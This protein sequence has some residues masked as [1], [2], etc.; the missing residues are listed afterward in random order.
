MAL[1][2]LAGAASAFAAIDTTLLEQP[3][4]RAS[5]RTFEIDKYA[6]QWRQAL[7]REQGIYA[8]VRFTAPLGLQ[9]TWDLAQDYRGMGQQTPG[10][11]A[12]RFMD[13]SPT[14]QLIEL[15]VR[16]LWRKLTLR[17]AVEREAPQR[18]R[19]ALL[20][21]PLGA[22]YGISTFT[23]TDTGT[24]VDLAIYLKPARRVPARLLLAVE[25]LAILGGTRAFLKACEQ[26]HN[27]EPI[28]RPRADVPFVEGLRS[29][30]FRSTSARRTR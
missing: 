4:P 18:L 28:K 6:V 17:F 14:R 19:F 3:W 24:V 23:P 21:S 8:G 20:E 30:R 16:V 1:G 9:A 26:Q 7:P 13:E 5:Q 11:D 29:R 25:R 10:V 22:Y 2:V 27:E 15:D 12:V